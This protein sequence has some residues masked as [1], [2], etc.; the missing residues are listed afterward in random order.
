MFNSVVK[1]NFFK[2]LRG[3]IKHLFAKMLCYFIFSQIMISASF[4]KGQK[5]LWGGGY[6]TTGQKDFT[7]FC[8][9]TLTWIMSKWEHFLFVWLPTDSR[10]Q[11]K[12]KPSNFVIAA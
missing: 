7:I 6:L 12:H 5:A 2:N 4:Q 11:L 8:C 3:F 10:L 1:G 9:K